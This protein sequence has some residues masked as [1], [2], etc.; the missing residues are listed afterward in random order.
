MIEI[1]QGDNLEVLASDD[2]PL[3]HLIYIDPPFNT[4]KTQKGSSGASYTDSHDDYLGWLRPRIIAGREK[5][6]PYGS[7]FLHLDPRESHYAKVLCDEIFGRDCFQNEIIWAYDYGGRSKRKWSSKH[8]VIL[9][10]TKHPKLYTY[11]Y[12]AIDRVPYMAPGL[13][14]PEKAALGKTPTDVWWHTIVPTMGKEKTGYPTQKPLGLLKRIVAVHS[15]PT[16]ILLDY[17]AGSGSFGEAGEVL[18]RDTYLV[19]NSPTA[20]ETMANRFI[21]RGLEFTA[22]SPP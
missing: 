10:Y 7:F 22:H 5:L 21:S 16:D 12:H 4:G 14:G 20:V 9:W 3:V 11:N 19:D 13:V 2:I 18:G 17:F 1:F 8:D 6:E 15:H